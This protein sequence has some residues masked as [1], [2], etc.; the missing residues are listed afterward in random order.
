MRTTLAAGALALASIAGTANADIFIFSGFD[1]P[2]GGIDPQAYGLRLDR[3]GPDTGPVTFS[4]ENGAG[5]SAVTIVLNTDDPNNAT[6]AITGTITGNTANGGTLF[7]QFFLDVT[8]TG[9]WD[10]SMFQADDMSDFTGSLTATS[11]GPGFDPFMLE[12]GT[13]MGLGDTLG[14]T[15]KD[16][17]GYIFRFGDDPAGGRLSSSDPLFE[18]FGWV[19]R[20]DDMAATQDFLFTARLDQV[21]PAP[22]TVALMGLA[23]IAAGRRRR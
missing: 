18:G 6:L 13:M 9:T 17:N 11:L 8:Y 15:A 1:H 5:A 22:G 14:L 23:G 16:R 3:F 20:D 10:G 2:G 4:F 12:D 7:G 19:R 21:I